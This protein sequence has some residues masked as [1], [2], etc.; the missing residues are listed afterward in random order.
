MEYVILKI[1]EKKGS[2]VESGFFK[3]G[4]IVSVSPL[5][6]QQLIDDGIAERYVREQRKM[7]DEE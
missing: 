7:K 3:S 1:I 5:M 4:S 2:F 6:A